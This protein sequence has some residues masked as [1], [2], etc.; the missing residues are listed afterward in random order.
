MFSPKAVAPR[1]AKR[2]GANP[3]MAGAAPALRRNFHG[4]GFGPARIGREMAPLLFFSGVSASKLLI[5]TMGRP[6]NFAEA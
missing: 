6:K 4:R 5:N 1:A 2:S 3:A